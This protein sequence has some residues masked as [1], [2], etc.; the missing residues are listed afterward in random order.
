V[1]KL[2]EFNFELLGKWC[3]RMLV[4]RGGLW[5]RVLVAR[6]GEEVERLE[7]RGRSVSTWWR[8]L[9]KIR[10]GVDSVGGSWFADSVV[11]KVRKR[12]N[13]SF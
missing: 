9:A 8:E 11:C 13:I 4:D 3:W 10:D 12:T 6:Y 5:Y 1:R 2:N 7:V